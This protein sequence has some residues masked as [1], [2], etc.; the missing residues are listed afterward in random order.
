MASGWAGTPLAGVP[1]SPSRSGP[2]SVTLAR[3]GVSKSEPPAVPTETTADAARPNATGD[4]DALWDLAETVARALSR[5][6]MILTQ[7][8]LRKPCYD[9]Y[10]L[11][12]IKF[13]SLPARDA[14]PEGAGCRAQSVSLT[15]PLNR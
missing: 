14:T 4:A 5:S 2:H 10:F 7:V 15:K 6:S 3:A 12:V 1:S 13:V 8:H 11:E 9:F